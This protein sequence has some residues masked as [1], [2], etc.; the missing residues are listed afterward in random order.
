MT[1]EDASTKM[2][3]QKIRAQ[4]QKGLYTRVSNVTMSNL[5][6][7]QTELDSEGEIPVL[8]QTIFDYNTMVEAQGSSL[9]CRLGRTRLLT[10]LSRSLW[11]S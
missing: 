1:C 8:L 4:L 11:P 3:T 10:V 5:R 6:G 2:G 9:L 7:C